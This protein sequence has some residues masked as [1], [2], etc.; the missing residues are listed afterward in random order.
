[1]TDTSPRPH[2]GTITIELELEWTTARDEAK[3][4]DLHSVGLWVVDAVQTALEGL[5]TKVSPD[6]RVTALRYDGDE[7]SIE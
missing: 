2:K 4:T 5:N 6:V 7:R 1:M 3:H